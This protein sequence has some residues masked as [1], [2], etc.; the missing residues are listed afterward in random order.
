MAVDQTRIVTFQDI[1]DYLESHSRNT[2]EKGDL[3]E[4]VATWYLR[5]DPEM[6]QVVGTVWRWN[7]PDNP[8]HTGHDVGIDAVAERSDEEGG[9]WAIQYK[10]YDPA[11]KLTY[12]E[13]STTF[14]SAEADDRYTGIIIVSAGEEL[15]QNVHEHMRSLRQNRGTAGMI[16]TPTVMETANVDWSLLLQERAQDEESRRKRTHSPKPHQQEAINQIQAKFE[17]CDRAKAIMACG[18]GKTLMSLRLAEERFKGGSCAD[19]LFCAPSIALVSQAMREWTNQ[20]RVEMRSLVV[21]SDAKASKIDEDDVLDDVVDVSFPANTDPAS[22][23]QRYRWTREHHPDAMVVVFTTYQSMQVIQDAQD[24]GLPRFGLCVC[25]EAHRTAGTKYAEDE[26]VASFQIVIDGAR[27]RA[28]KRLFMTATPKVYGDNVKTKAG[29]VAAELYSMDDEEKYG[30]IAYELTFAEAVEKKLLCDYRVVVLAINEDAVPGTKIVVPR[31]SDEA[32]LDVGDT[33]K[34]IGCWRGLATHG[35]EARRRLDAYEGDEAGD[36][37]DFLLVDD[38]DNWNVG[39]GELDREMISLDGAPVE[40]LHRAVGFCSTIQ[41]SK[42]IDAAFEQVVKSYVESTG[43]HGPECSL[44]HVD[45]SMDSKVRAKKLQW[46]ASGEGADECRILTNARC[47]AE[48]VD[49]PS[50]DAVIFFSPK[51]SKVDV[52]QAVGRVMRTFTDERTGREKELGY[53]ILPVVI[54]SDMTPEEALNKSDTFD[55]VWGVLQ[56]LRSHDQR[57][58]AYINSLPM[59]K[60]RKKGGSLG[61]GTKSGHPDAG[62]DSGGERNGEQGEFELEFGSTILERA[63]YA[64]AVEKCGSKVYWSSWAEDVG[65]IARSH[66]D[67]INEAI[68]SDP[69]AREAMASFLKSLRDS[70]NPGVSQ[71]AAVEMVA[72]HMV[73]LPVFDALFGDYAFAESNPVSVAI[74]EF[75][76][77]LEGHG[78]GDMS[79]SDRQSLDE[80]YASVRRR[81]SFCRTDSNRQA[82]IKDL[83]NEFF[84]KAFKS[85]SEKLGIVYTPIEIV[86]YILHAADRAMQREFGKRLCDEG[87]HI[88]DPF[89]GT[90]SFM[91][92]LVSDPDL[93]PIDRLEHKYRQELHSNEILLL[94]YYIMVVNVEYAYHSR[95]GGEYVPFEGAVL[96][97]TFQ[98]DEEGDELDLD[99][100]IDNSQRILDQQDAPIRVI[101]GNPPYSV[102]Q[103]NANDDNQNE[104]Y[105]TLEQRIRETYSAHTSATNKNSLMDSYIEAFRWASD[106]IG[107][108]GIVCFVSNAGWLRSEAGAGMRRCLS[109]EFSSIYIFDLLGHNQYRRMTREQMK[110]QGENVFGNGSTAAIAITML[111]KNPD[112]QEHGNIHY[113]CIDESLNREQ[114]L[115]AIS[116]CKDF[117]PE[118][119][120]LTQDRHGDWLDQRDDSWYEFAPVAISHGTKKTN[121]GIWSIW[122]NGIKTNQDSWV[123]NYSRRLVEHNVEKLIKN[124]NSETLKVHGD[125]NKVTYDSKNYSWSGF[126]LDHVKHHHQIRFSP[127]NIIVGEYRPFCKQFLYYSRDLNQ[128]YGQPAKLFPPL[129]PNETAP[130]IVICESAEK[131]ELSVLVSDFLPDL[132]FVGSIQCFPLYWYEKDDDATMELIPAEKEKVVRDAWGNRYIRHDAITDQAL[133]AFR[134]AYPVAFHNRKAKDGPKEITKKDIFWYIYGILHSPEYRTR[135]SANLQRELPRIPLV[136]DFEKFCAAGRALGELHLGYESVEP[137]PDLDITG[138]LPGEDPGPVEKLK[139]AKKRN[140]ETGKMEK[141]FTKLVYNKQVTISNIPESAQ[142]YVVN[143]RSPLDWMIDRYQVKTDK[144]TG[145]VNDPNEYSDDPRYILDLIGRLVTVSMRTNEI[146]AAL[147]PLREIEKPASWPEA[148]ST[149]L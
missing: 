107:D 8:M 132:H 84:S 77:E 91:A 72:Q 78:V 42:D 55:V 36:T 81:A 52:V 114:K 12:G 83:Y 48:G 49:V 65:R 119:E 32:E 96:T 11:H 28:D 30:P 138:A 5:N 39:G 45:G 112:S 33:A 17:T 148:W 34:I 21:C 18:T 62:E 117:D 93:M 110:R 53:I 105:P 41:A 26:D 118:W 109:K 59:R 58:D 35:E 27:I 102:G 74:T 140:P 63:V 86:D 116:S 137:W 67:Q 87:V 147:P 76:G 92:E 57:I 50:L 64:K 37:P 14:A 61:I 120:T 104:H 90:G 51:R 3:W 19:V 98:M 40:P 145:I 139:W 134:D 80:L 43:E 115:A 82:L 38:F 131:E 94:A 108:E 23:L 126:M 9:Y 44:D 135:F 85:T 122:S 68:Q 111:I 101:V 125:I 88:L 46:L 16:L 71:Q 29:E 123:W 100:F 24:A 75:L 143:G 10:N 31:G 124:T 7:D 1:M 13:L 121:L 129:K 141:D 144:N 2:T 97:D 130:N 22:L 103:K 128:R 89:A 69:V 70:L 60:P 106:R 113:H 133:Q 142:E 146:V 95:M 136:E 127:E 79:A 149:D 73:T 66:V 56:A 47:L 4:R 99:T 6:Q 25:D 15:S 54:P 20:A